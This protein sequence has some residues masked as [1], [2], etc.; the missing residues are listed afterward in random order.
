M[1]ESFVWRE[2]VHPAGLLHDKKKYGEKMTKI[3][4]HINSLEQG[5]AER[6][7]SNLAAQFAADG[8]EVC[9]LTE[10]QAKN[11][12]RISDKVRRLSVGLRKEDEKCSRV[13]KFLKRIGYLHKALKQ[14]KPDI[15]ISFAKRANY[16]ALMSAPGTKVPVLMSVRTTPVGHYDSKT[17]WLQIHLLFSRAAGCVFQT[18][19]AR[20]F[21]PKGIREKSRIILNPINDKYIG[22]PQAAYR[23]KE[24]VHVGRLVDFK[25]QPMLI[26]AFGNVHKNYPEYSL[27]IYGGD[28]KDGTKAVL[29]DCIRECGLE[30]SVTLMGANDDL[31]EQMEHAAFFTFTSDWE[32][33]PNA[34]MEAMALGLPVISTDC[35]CGGP[36]TLIEPEVNGLL[37]PIKDQKAL[38]KAMVRLIKDPDFAEGLGRNARKLGE[39]ANSHAIYLQWKSYV[40]EII[41]VKGIKNHKADGI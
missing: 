24:I 8:Y 26:R 2:T 34:V 10:W 12:F 4:F 11:E 1:P 41:A 38:E 22:R 14:E 20:D 17:D 30:D 25:N 29:E 35:P 19:G 31:A 28:S 37:I 33:L 23:T 21:F 9:I 7:V 13:T 16:R 18:T 5:G 3:A 40:E 6:V 39:M 27:K 32:G 36:G 15:L